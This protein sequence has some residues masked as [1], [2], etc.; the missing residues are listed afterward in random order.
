MKPWDWNLDILTAS[1]QLPEVREIARDLMG[2][3]H[4]QTLGYLEHVMQFHPITSRAA[5]IAYEL[6]MHATGG[7]A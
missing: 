5:E 3:Q 7:W 2:M 1:H 4:D 6:W